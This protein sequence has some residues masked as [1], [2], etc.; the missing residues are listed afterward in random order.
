M[1]S[2]ASTGITGAIAAPRSPNPAK[3]AVIGGTVGLVVDLIIV[4]AYI[5]AVQHKAGPCDIAGENY[6]NC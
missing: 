6:P 3:Y 5:A 4:S 1:T 2:V